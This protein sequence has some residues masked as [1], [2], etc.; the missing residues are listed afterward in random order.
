MKKAL[1]LLFIICFICCGCSNKDSAML[2]CLEA[3]YCAE[4]LSVYIDD[5]EATITKEFCLENSFK[6]YENDRSCFIR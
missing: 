2:N 1:F 5:K 6:W 4:G 3:G